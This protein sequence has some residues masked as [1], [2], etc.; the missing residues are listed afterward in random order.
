[1]HL[2][3]QTEPFLRLDETPLRRV[4]EAFHE[5]RL[6]SG[7]AVYV[8]GA[9]I[10]EIGFIASGSVSL[11]VFANHDSFVRFDILTPGDFIG[12]EALALDNGSPVKAFCE[13]FVRCFFQSK[14][15]FL[16]AI[17]PHYEVREFFYRKAIKRLVK[18][19]QVLHGEEG[20]GLLKGMEEN[21]TVY[22]PRAIEKALVYIDKNYMKNITLD[23]IA[24]I[25]GTSKYHFTRIF[26]RN[27]GSTFKQYLNGKRIEMAKHFMKYEDMTVSEAGIAV[28]YNDLAY[29][30]RVF[31]HQEGVA[32]SQYRR[33]IK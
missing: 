27:T 10:R 25:N 19:I 23:K 8:D 7:R 3:S 30:S 15:A 12:L 4:S 5:R 32:P 33:G 13:S 21:D 20:H 31:Q 22:Y 26:K 29:F 28:G 14:E 16:Q 18:A 2:L 17:T 11:G 1:M 9:P 6:P 24:N